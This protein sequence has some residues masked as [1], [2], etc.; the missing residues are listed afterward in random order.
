VQLDAIEAG[1][2][3]RSGR[4][5]IRIS[6][7]HGIQGV[8]EDDPA[9]VAATYAALIDGIAPLGLAYLHALADPRSA[10]LVD[11]RRRFGGPFIANDGFSSVTDRTS[12]Q[13]FLDEGVADVVAV[14]RAFLA[15]PDLPRRWEI[16]APMNA[17]VQATFYGGG[18]EGYTDYPFLEA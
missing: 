1:L 6:P 17:P 3:G 7:A 11:L 4:V 14:G 8:V 15:N 13:S 2:T 5:G 18:A 9:D 12:A 16:G 10:L